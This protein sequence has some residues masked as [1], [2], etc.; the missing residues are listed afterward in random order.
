MESR[1]YRARLPQRKT[2]LADSKKKYSTKQRRRDHLGILIVGIANTKQQHEAG[3][4]GESF[5]RSKTSETSQ[6]TKK[7]EFAYSSRL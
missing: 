3:V 1:N 5:A 7:K 4:H 2:C 6:K